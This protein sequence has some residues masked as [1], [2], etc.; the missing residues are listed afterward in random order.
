MQSLPDVCAKHN[1]Y[2]M[3]TLNAMISKHL[4][5]TQWL[6]DVYTKQ[7]LTDA[8]TKNNNYQMTTLNTMVSRHLKRKL[9]EKFS[10]IV[11][12]EIAAYWK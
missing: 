4:H 10:H 3:S 8:Y 12:N 5:S 1:G 6:A 2:Q 11:D 7:W 9:D